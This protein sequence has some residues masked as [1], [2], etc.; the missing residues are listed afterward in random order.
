MLGVSLGQVG[1]GRP[2]YQLSAGFG[3][4]FRIGFRKATYM[5]KLPLANRPP[6]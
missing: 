5:S 4:L 3:T 6:A 2:S 1:F